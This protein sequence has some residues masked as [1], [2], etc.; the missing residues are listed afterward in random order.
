M[1]E[2]EDCKSPYLNY[3]NKEK[4]EPLFGE[5]KCM[6]NRNIPIMDAK[7]S[8]GSCPAKS[9]PGNPAARVYGGERARAGSGAGGVL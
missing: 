8:A 7:E 2:S 6:R 5:D 9:V 3:M 1:K 4:R